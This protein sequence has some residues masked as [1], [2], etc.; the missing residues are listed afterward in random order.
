MSKY[1][2]LMWLDVTSNIKTNIYSVESVKIS[3]L[4][5]LKVA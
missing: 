2:F 3:H 4:A 1:I 5:V